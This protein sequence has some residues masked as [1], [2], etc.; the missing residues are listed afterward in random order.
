MEPRQETASEQGSVLLRLAFCL[1][2]AL[3]GCA[4]ERAAVERKLLADKGDPARREGVV[5]HYVVQC[6]DVLE[7]RVAFRPDLSRPY[8]VGADGCIDLGDYGRLRVEGK[9][10][11]EIAQRLGE[12]LGLS[13]AD[14]RV[15]VAEFHS[16]HLLL[17]GQVIGWQRTIPYH[18][19]E[20]VLDVLQRVGG[21][22]KGAEP[23]DVYVVRAHMLEGTRPEIFQID[24]D[25]IVVD[26]DMSTNIR[27]QPYD[28]IYVG[29][30]RKSRVERNVPPWLRPV[31]QVFWR[32]TP[33]KD[34][35]A[36]E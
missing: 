4:G 7:L 28:Q 31:F 30:T 3:A 8:P 35:K 33:D 17:F 34:A 29:E 13:A 23:R 19:Q 26:K 1:A 21:I 25:A 6:P 15:R 22:T 10:T 11:P 18:G 2:L 12:I 14:V 9:T 24:L 20:T 5:E 36:T 27:L 16:Q 32:T